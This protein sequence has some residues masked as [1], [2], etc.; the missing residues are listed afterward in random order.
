[1]VGVVW[2]GDKIVNCRNHVDYEAIC[3]LMNGDMKCMNVL[4]VNPLSP[5]CAK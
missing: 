2:E 1:V 3:G 5:Q 4:C